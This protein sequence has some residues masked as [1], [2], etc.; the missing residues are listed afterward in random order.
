M[1]SVIPTFK[2]VLAASKRIRG[3]AVR[4]PLLSNAELDRATGAR[5]LCKAENLQRVGAFKFRGAYNRLSMIPEAER[6]KGVVACSSGNHAQGVAEAARLLGLP[7]TIVM[8]ADAPALKLARTER[9]GAEVVR[10]DR[11]TE[12]REAI[13]NAI[14]AK[15]GAQFVHPYNDAG[16]IAGQGTLGVEMVEQA[17]EQGAEL[18]LV[19]VPV[20]GGGMAG[21]VALALEALAPQ[22]AV[23]MVEPQGFDDYARSLDAGARRRNTAVTGSICDALMANSP[24][25]ISFSILQTRAAGALTVSD[26]EVLKA[27][28]FAFHELKLV[29]EPGGAAALAALLSGK[30]DAAGKTVGVVLSGGNIDPSMMAR[31]LA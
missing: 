8:P 30:L 2:G 12:D 7:A 14:A 13:A 17:D 31:A 24:G 20:S 21:G 6:A 19:L 27:I 1:T 10:Y 23:I 4:T 18:D 9:S 25:E 22:C 15:T 26:E 16:V 3:V 29:L 28:A 11:A 5:I